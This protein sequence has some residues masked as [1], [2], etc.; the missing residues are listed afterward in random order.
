M[1]GKSIAGRAANIKQRQKMVHSS[2]YW[3]RLDDAK[4]D[5]NGNLIPCMKVTTKEYVCISCGV[6]KW[7]GF[8]RCPECQTLQK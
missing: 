2:N 6:K 8:M 4:K 5:E 7:F 1:S 3:R